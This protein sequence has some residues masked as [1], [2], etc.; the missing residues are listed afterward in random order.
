MTAKRIAVD[1]IESSQPLGTQ[2]G[3]T[4]SV[5]PIDRGCDCD[6]DFTCSNCAGYFTEQH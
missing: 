3:I 6:H 2:D 5:Y 1:V 4:Y